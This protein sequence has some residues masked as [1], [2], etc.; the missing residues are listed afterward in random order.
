M[1]TR[2]NVIPL[3]A[4]DIDLLNQPMK[5]LESVGKEDQMSGVTITCSCMAREPLLF[6]ACDKY[7]IKTKQ[8]RRCCTMPW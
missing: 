5:V 8:G 2:G 1:Y 3:C 7:K 6:S 4:L